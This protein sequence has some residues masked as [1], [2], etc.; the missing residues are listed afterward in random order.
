MYLILNFGDY[1]QSGS[2]GLLED[3]DEIPQILGSK[4]IGF[5]MNH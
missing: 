1:N 4:L 3:I 5:C 2:G